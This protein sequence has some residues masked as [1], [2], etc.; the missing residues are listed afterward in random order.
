M[1]FSRPIRSS[2]RAAYEIVRR[3]LAIGAVGI[4]WKTMGQLEVA[5]PLQHAHCFP[6]RGPSC[7]EVS[8]PTKN[9]YIFVLNRL[10][11]SVVY[12][13]LFSATRCYCCVATVWL[14]EQADSLITLRM[15]TW[16]LL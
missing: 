7:T 2:I 13:M 1:T 11:V 6:G 9:K 8:S 15:R 14:K 10:F 12:G 4:S 5:F 16:Y 3:S